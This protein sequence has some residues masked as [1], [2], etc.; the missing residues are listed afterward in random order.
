[1]THSNAVPGIELFLD[2]PAAV[3]LD[4]VLIGV[5]RVVNGGP[6]TV[7]VSARVNLIEGDL[8]VAVTGPD[9]RTGR[10]GWPYPVD[11][12][13]RTI[14]LGPGEA[15]AGSIPLLVDGGLTPVFPVA[16]RYSLTAR[17]QA[18]PG[19]E[20]IGAPVS[21]ERQAPQDDLAAQA[22]QDRDVLQSLLSAAEMGQAAGS[23]AALAIGGE[24][25]ARFLSG[26]A[27]GSPG[28]VRQ[29]AQELAVGVGDRPAD[30]LSAA[31]A[32]NAVLPTGLY[33]GDQRREAV[34]DALTGVT[35]ARVR[36]MLDGLPHDAEGGI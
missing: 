24:P 14:E 9:G 13:P 10:A 33:T 32:L 18:A 29:A 35:D 22:L 19:A 2:V 4:E 20:L 23:L 26:L 1:V 5:V 17:F 31:S 7:T 27:L 30:P 15:L 11:S 6:G 36:A 16:G 3:P 21:V 25:M 8:T 12:L 34:I 28:Q